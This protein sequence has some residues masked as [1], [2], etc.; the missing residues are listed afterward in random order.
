MRLASPLAAALALMSTAVANQAPQPTSIDPLREQ[1][2]AAQTFQL[3]GDLERAEAVYARDVLPRALRRLA[4]LASAEGRQDDARQYL[5]EARGHQPDDPLVTLD[6]VVVLLRAGDSQTARQLAREVSSADPKNARAL[7]LYGKALLIAGENAE[8]RSVLERS[9]RQAT[10]FDTGL[11]LAYA[12]LRTKR[13]PEARALFD[14]MMAGN[15][16]AEIRSLIA[17]A[18]LEN[19]LVEPAASYLEQA[20]RLNADHQPSRRLLDDLKA[21]RPFDRASLPT[22]ILQVPPAPDEERGAQMRHQVTDVVANSYFNL[23]VIYSRRQRAAEAAVAM[24]RAR[25]WKPDL[26]GIDRATGIALFYADRFSEAIPPLERHMSAFPTDEGARKLLDTSYLMTGRAPDVKAST[27]TPSMAL[28]PRPTDV[29]GLAAEIGSGPTHEVE[30]KLWALLAREPANARALV[31][32][33]NVLLSANRPLEAESIFRRATEVAASDR[34]AWLGRVKAITITGRASDARTALDAALTNLPGDPALEYEMAR[35]LLELDEPRAALEHLAR[36]PAEGR[37]PGAVGVEIGARIALGE[38][39]ATR[40]LLS[41]ASSKAD[42]TTVVFLVNLLLKHGRSSEALSLAEAG[43]ARDMKTAPL[44][45]AGARARLAEG[46]R[47]GAER[48]YELALDADS[49]SIAALVGLGDLIA[50]RDPNRATELFLIAQSHGDRSPSL[51]RSL[52]LSATAALRFSEALDAAHALTAIRP[53]DVEAV[54]LVGTI[55]LQ[56]M[57][58]AAAEKSFDEMAALDP[59]DARAPLGIGIARYGQRRYSGRRSGARTKPGARPG[60]GRSALPARARRPGSGRNS[61]RRCSS[62]PRRSAGASAPCS[63]RH[64]GQSAGRGGRVRARTARPRARNRARTRIAGRVLPARPFV[65]TDKA[66]GPRAPGDGAI[67]T[68][69]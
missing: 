5:E 60:A 44:L 62:R 49:M 65:C 19:G 31:L 30:Q 69:A 38:V 67:P 26:E 63:P 54:N 61:G 33:G 15:S 16:S 66:A 41:D 64:V 14:E 21:G 22:V 24:T 48:W 29:D 10:E 4:A 23:G 56:R 28:P 46:D 53:M 13:L 50:A 68:I 25:N 20:L 9:M 1:Y 52:A 57:D 6:F 43:H 51:L 11:S 36:V 3:A 32:L 35:T 40:H 27:A 8:A 7:R 17:R 2:Q 12:N 42:E 45:V 47:A 18:Y 59:R 55:Q 37:P 58:W 39:D 34:E